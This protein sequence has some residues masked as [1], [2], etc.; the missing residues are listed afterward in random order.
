MQCHKGGC[1]SLFIR[2]GS[3]GLTASPRSQPLVWLENLH[4][5]G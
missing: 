2:K 3:T 5:C 1:C 4:A